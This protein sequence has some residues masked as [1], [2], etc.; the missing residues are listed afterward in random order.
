MPSNGYV[1]STCKCG[2]KGKGK[3]NAIPTQAG[4]GHERSIRLRFS[5]FMDNRAHEGGKVSSPTHR[6]PLPNPHEKAY[7]WYSFLLDTESIPGS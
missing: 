6:P 5:E 4:S 7:H 3:G 2:T 1:Y